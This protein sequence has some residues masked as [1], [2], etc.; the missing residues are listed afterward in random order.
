MDT[1]TLYDSSVELIMENPED[2]EKQPTQAGSAEEGASIFLL[3]GNTE[4]GLVYSGFLGDSTLHCS[5]DKLS[6]ATTLTLH[7]ESEP[8]VTLLAIVLDLS[9]L[10][11]THPEG[12][13]KDTGRDNNLQKG[14]CAFLS[15]SV[16]YL[17]F[18]H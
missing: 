6:F 2:L 9:L 4:E 18:S 3:W 5:C 8:D 1:I 13:E 15:L 17:R 16:K 11:Q 10:F 14:P 7:K 12:K